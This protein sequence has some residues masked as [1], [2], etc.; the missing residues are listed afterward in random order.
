MHS[1]LLRCSVGRAFN[2]YYFSISDNQILLFFAQ[3]PTR[4]NIVVA[5]KEIKITVRHSDGT[6]KRECIPYN[7]WQT[8]YEIVVNI[9]QNFE[10][11]H[12]LKHLCKTH[13][14]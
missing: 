8:G 11:K 14:S 9:L 7:F 13:D 5:G 6:E 10:W 12:S 2:G 4:P 3:I 1:M